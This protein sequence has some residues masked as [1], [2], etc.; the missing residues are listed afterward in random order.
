M[1]IYVN[2]IERKGHGGF[3]EVS[4]EGIGSLIKVEEQDLLNNRCDLEDY[5]YNTALDIAESKGLNREEVSVK[6][7]GAL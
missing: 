7:I 1:N 6:I 5:I 3:Y 4:I 2:V